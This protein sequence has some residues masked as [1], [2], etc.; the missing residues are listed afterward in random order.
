MQDVGYGFPRIP[1][2]GNRVNKAAGAAPCRPGVPG[3]G[4]RTAGA[5]DPLRVDV[6]REK[7]SYE[8]RAS[9]QSRSLRNYRRRIYSRVCSFAR[10]GYKTGLAR[11]D[12]WGELPGKDLGEGGGAL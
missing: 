2:L 3:L 9:V 1:L 7:D 11:A 8:V 5:A 4:R 10:R 6:F 12:F